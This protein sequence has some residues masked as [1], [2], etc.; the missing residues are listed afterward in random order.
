MI[1][2]M[3]SLV[4]LS[5]LSW[6]DSCMSCQ[7]P[8]LPSGD[9]GEEGNTTPPPE[10]TAEDTFDAPPPPPCDFP[11]EEPN[12]TPSDA[13]AIETGLWAC[14][15]LAADAE[16]SGGGTS[17]T[18]FVVFTVPETGWIEMWA[19]GQD[20]GSYADLQMT[21]TF[22]RDSD[23]AVVGPKKHSPGSMDPRIALPVQAGDVIDVGI[24][25]ENYAG[26]DQQLWE[27]LASLLKDPPVYWNTLEDEDVEDPGVNDTLA[28]ASQTLVDGTQVYGYLGIDDVADI[29][30]IDVPAGTWTVEADVEAYDSGS[31]LDSKLS[32]MRPDSTDPSGYDVAVSN[33]NGREAD[34]AP[35]P[36][37][38]YEVEGPATWAV[39]VSN[40]GTF[41]SRF[42]WYVLGVTLEEVVDAGG[43]P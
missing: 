30:W 39:K 38:T 9:N 36:K 16:T 14:G 23:A 11:E 34:L 6:Y 40:A 29:Y 42:H 43:T 19:R 37:V 8:D 20:I 10:D 33:N 22:N 27:F 25:A 12:N 21:I 2:S 1:H 3:F 18:D 26:T 15:V 31:P 28:L 7:P 5:F 35:D 17:A 41:S 4:L 32:L 13:D 24:S